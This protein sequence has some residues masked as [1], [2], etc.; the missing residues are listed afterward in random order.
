MMKLLMELNGESYRKNICERA[1]NVERQW[2]QRTKG[3]KAKEEMDRK[4]KAKS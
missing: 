1:R 3:R 4:G 2:K